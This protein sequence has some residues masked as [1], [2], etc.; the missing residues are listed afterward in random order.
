MEKKFTNIDELFKN[1]LMN[2][3]VEPPAHL[4]NNI[5][6]ELDN[7]GNIDDLFKKS[8]HENEVTPP[9]YVWDNINASLD[10]LDNKRKNR[11][12]WMLG[13][14]AAVIIAFIT[15]YFIADYVQQKSDVEPVSI[16]L[17][18]QNKSDKDL[19]LGKENNVTHPQNVTNNQTKSAVANTGK[20]NSSNQK[21]ALSANTTTA[22]NS[23]LN[24]QGF[25]TSN[26]KGKPTK[27]NSIQGI[28]DNNKNNG[29]VQRNSFN[30]KQLNKDDNGVVFVDESQENMLV[31]ES[32]KTDNEL[33][34]TN[35]NNQETEE[36]EKENITVENTETTKQEASTKNQTI[37]LY[38]DLD[39]VNS[40]YP[41]FSVSPFFSPMY[42][43]RNSFNNEE[44]YDP[45]APGGDDRFKHTTRFSYQAGVLLGYNF[46]R[47][48]SIHIGCS[49]NQITHSTGRGQL[50]TMPFSQAGIYDSALT[51]QTSAGELTGISVDPNLDN[52]EIGPT[53]NIEQT[54]LQ[55]PIQQVVQTI[56][57]IE[58]P[59][60]FKYRFAS[61]RVGFLLTG[62]FGTG[63]IVRNDAFAENQTEYV[64]FGETANIRNV[65]FNLILGAGM[66][67]QI[68]PWMYFTFEPTFRYSLMNWSMKEDVKVNP[69]MI[70][71][72]TGVSFRF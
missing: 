47:K 42:A 38:A 62:G 8:L 69:I 37:D 70:G 28:A 53:I 41:L 51:V 71:A 72:N 33:A 11:I 36:T 7:A 3:E 49:Y 54:L 34:V 26:K 29:T 16:A 31:K 65:N 22:V 52:Q 64:R 63:F 25:N 21:S 60:L 23:H 61:S 32:I 24:P 44:K 55:S 39:P 59:V 9:A 17:H 45:I 10:K 1:K 2:Y 27:A 50:Q 40:Y 13:S 30:E 6:Q 48:I 20:S 5:S 14:G 67:V 58:V 4:W 46:T 35:N 66:D 43:I 68:T 12:W 15:G 19:L 18:E 56:G 57:F